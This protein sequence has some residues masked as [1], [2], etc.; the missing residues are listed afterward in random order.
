MPEY[1]EGKQC[2][3]KGLTK[4]G[5]YLVR[6]MIEAGMLIGV[7]HM[8]ELARDRVL[9]I[10]A[11]HHYPV[12]SGHTGTGGSWTP[13]EL[14]TLYR[15]GG[16]ASATPDAAPDLARKLLSFRAYRGPKHYFGVG[17]GTD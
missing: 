16:L 2:N 7:D 3:T 8:S 17:L 13:K 15:N 9:K 12:V 11:Q 6:R 5:A 10:A 4:L 14:R 1:P